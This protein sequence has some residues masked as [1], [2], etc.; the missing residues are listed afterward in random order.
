MPELGPVRTSTPAD[1]AMARVLRMVTM[2]IAA[3]AGFTVDRVDDVALATTEAFSIVIA[4]PGTASVECV[5]KAE[6]G[7]ISV[8]MT[9]VA[10][11]VGESSSD[12]WPIDPL[13]DRVLRSVTDQVDYEMGP[14][15][16]A[17]AVIARSS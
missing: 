3:S 12:P 14:T 16:V 5:A 10:E 17:F 1:P 6:M 9:S 7:R 2:G 4:T 15:R 13:A 8:Q 11:T